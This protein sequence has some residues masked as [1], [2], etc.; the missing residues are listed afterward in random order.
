LRVLKQT[1]RHAQ[2]ASY[3]QPNHGGVT[4]SGGEPIMQPHFVAALFMEAHAMGL[5][6]CIDTNGQ[7]NKHTN[8]CVFLWLRVRPLP[9]TRAEP[10]LPCKHPS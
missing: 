10:C 7:G 8:W 9:S 5:T 6:T 3:L 4:V 2:V 1:R